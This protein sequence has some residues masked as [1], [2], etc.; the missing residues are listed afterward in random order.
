MSIVK[1]RR[2]L[3]ILGGIVLVVGCYMGWQMAK[4]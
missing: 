3:A 4:G 2:I 1:P